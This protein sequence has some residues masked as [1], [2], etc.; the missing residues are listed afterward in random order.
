[1][2]LR[3]GVNRCEDYR[4]AWRGRNR[5]HDETLIDN[6]RF[7]TIKTSTAVAMASPHEFSHC[8]FIFSVLITRKMITALI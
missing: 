6:A 4:R 8:S 2:R 1:M 7:C 5:G 3:I